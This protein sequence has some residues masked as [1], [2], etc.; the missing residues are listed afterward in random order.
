[1]YSFSYCLFCGRVLNIFCF[2]QKAEGGNG[3]RWERGNKNLCPIW[4][5]PPLGVLY[6]GGYSW[7]R[8]RCND[9][10][11]SYPGFA[12]IV[13]VSVFFRLFLEEIRI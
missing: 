4:S 12:Y 2:L 11:Y 6:I 3:I 9:Y 13:Y 5:F 8:Q 1:M 7:G 10:T